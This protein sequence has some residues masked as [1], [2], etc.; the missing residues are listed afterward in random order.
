[1]LTCTN[2]DTWIAK[3]MPYK[4][5]VCAQL[6]AIEETHKS[7]GIDMCN[8]WAGLLIIYSWFVFAL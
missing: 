8:Y 4:K 1:M 7:F 3:D 6:R 5:T 2:N